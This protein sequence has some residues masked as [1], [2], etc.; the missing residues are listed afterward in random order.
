MRLRR[1]PGPPLLPAES[2][3]FQDQCGALERVQGPRAR[4]REMNSDLLQRPEL[5]WKRLPSALASENT[6]E[7]RPAPPRGWPHGEPVLAVAAAMKSTMK[8]T[9]TQSLTSGLAREELHSRTGLHPA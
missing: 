8:S 6:L 7:G 3:L 5:A 4:A 1:P 2:R 9:M